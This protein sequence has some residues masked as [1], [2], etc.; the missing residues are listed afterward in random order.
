MSKEIDNDIVFSLTDLKSLFLKYRRK[1]FLFSF[2]FGSLS[3]GYFI[4]KPSLYKVQGVFKEYQE[5]KGDAGGLRD[6]LSG[7]S[8]SSDSQATSMMKSY[9]LL[10]DVAENLGLQCNVRIERS[11]LTRLTNRIKENIAANLKK[12]IK[13]IDNF[14]F[15]NVKYDKEDSSSFFLRLEKDKSFG[16][17]SLNKKLLVKG[18]INKPVSFNDITFTLV[19][20]PQATQPGKYYTL[21]FA[22]LSQIVEDLKTQIDISTSKLNKSFLNISAYDRDRHKAGRIVT[23]IMEVYK[24][25]LEK[26]NEEFSKEQ[27]TYLKQR[28]GELKSCVND[29]F[30]EYVDYLTN[31]IG[32]KG[33]LGVDYEIES[34]AIPHQNY[35]NRIHKIDFELAKLH[36]DI[37]NRFA[38]VYTDSNIL[39]ETTKMRSLKQNKD[40]L[41]C[42]LFQKKQNT[43]ISY[44][45]DE[46]A[47]EDNAEDNDVLIDLLSKKELLVKNQAALK[48]ELE[49]NKD[50]LNINNVNNK[51]L[52]IADLAEEK[53]ELKQLLADIGTNKHIAF[54]ENNNSSAIS[55]VKSWYQSLN[56]V[57]KQVPNDIQI[58]Y[59][60]SYLKNYINLIEVEEKQ[61]KD[62][63][64]LEFGDKNEFEGINLEIIKNLYHMT[65]EH[66]NDLEVSIKELSYALK[67]IEDPNV[68]LSIFESILKDRVSSAISMRVSDLIKKIQDDKNRSL[69]EI[70]ILKNE[71]GL[72]KELLKKHIIETMNLKKINLDHLKEKIKFLQYTTLDLNNREISL[73]DNQLQDYLKEK[74]EGL[75]LEKESINKYLKNLQKDMQS[76]P[77]QWK[78]EKELNFKTEMG[79]KMMQA[80]TQLIETKTISSHLN[81]VES[82]IL[83]Y[84]V[85]PV[86]PMPS[87]VF[88][89]AIIA[90][91]VG[92]FFSYCY[93]F[94]ITMLKGFP[95]SLETLLS[96][97][98]IVCGKLSFYCDGPNVEYVHDSDLES[99]RKIQDFID[100]KQSKKI[101]SLLE[102]CGP[103]YSF[104]LA[105][106]YVKK[107]KKVIIV[108]CDFNIIASNDEIPGLLQYL[109]G[110][111]DICIRKGNGCDYI[112]SGGSS[113][114]GLELMMTG[115]FSHLLEE[116]K[117]KYD[118]V[119]LVT[120][121]D[122]SYA[123]S[124]FFTKIS[125]NMIVTISEE[126]INI[127]RPFMKAFKSREKSISFVT[128][129]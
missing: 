54:S 24:N 11:L 29:S 86:S 37:P 36:Q 108:S 12:K 114:F 85:L 97:G 83:D 115:K 4:L 2:I 118:A 94:F 46:N 67:K 14:Q 59:F 74:K 76:I 43:M 32:Y 21:S 19:K 99:L 84:P 125:D 41:A 68:D 128:I 102:N 64:T 26:E 53:K 49:M 70:Q 42:S 124:R 73:L 6:L 69:K 98:K 107:S 66:V 5:R 91:F 33:F 58:D 95:L 8:V 65:Y 31:N 57:S 9:T 71:L 127:V 52:K 10:S 110:D 7:G 55:L 78:L 93:Y 123:E 75:V 22:R 101:V 50:R 90:A 38:F 80:I 25:Y 20:T 45:S 89:Y 27:L 18:E 121:A 3:F 23:T 13:D 112:T 100:L 129:S 61:L 126:P 30:D 62:I 44:M 34:V 60:R 92:C 40:N 113:R 122:L 79:L 104:S 28:Q 116:L 105:Q 1:I 51:L 120:R 16:V 96:L 56:N 63:N 39:A 48:I 35:I 106:L 88:L 82:K 87:H 81:K 103:D 109:E 72:E 119:L 117:D 15:T 77:K 17:Y 111:K 47:A